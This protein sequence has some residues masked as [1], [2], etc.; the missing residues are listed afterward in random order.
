VDVPFALLFLLVAY[1]L[2]ATL[3]VMT[4][5]LEEVSYHRYE[6]FR[7]RLLLVGWAL[8]ENLGYRQLT[9]LWRLQGLVK[10][11]RGRREWGAMERRGFTA[12]PAEPRRSVKP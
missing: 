7:D 5:A 3:T 6:R 9:V 4:L 8:L 2:G 1:G 11:L 12:P 10:Y